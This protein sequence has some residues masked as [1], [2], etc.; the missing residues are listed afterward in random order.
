MAFEVNCEN[1]DF[2]VICEQAEKL[3]LLMFQN[4]YRLYLDK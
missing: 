1:T 2:T 4:V 3:S